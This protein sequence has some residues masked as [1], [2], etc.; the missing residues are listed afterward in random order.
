MEEYNK[1]LELKK[2]H[3]GENRIEL[4]NIYQNIANVNESKICE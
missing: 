1:A 3:F 2:L 4:T